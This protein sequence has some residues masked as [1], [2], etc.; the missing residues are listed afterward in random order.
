MSLV[1]STFNGLLTSKLMNYINENTNVLPNFQ[2]DINL[3]K[4]VIVGNDKLISKLESQI[5]TEL[6]YNTKLNVSNFNKHGIFLVN[7][8]NAVDDKTVLSELYNIGCKVWLVQDK[9]TGTKI[10]E[11]FDESV[12]SLLNPKVQLFP[13]CL[14][15]CNRYLKQLHRETINFKLLC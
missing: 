10:N 3:I 7:Y 4:L 15:T 14:S 11:V 8:L 13:G 2:Q 9:E 12:N 1:H 5:S 6:G